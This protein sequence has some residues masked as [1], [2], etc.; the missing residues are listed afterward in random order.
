MEEMLY[1]FN[2]YTN[3]HIQRETVDEYVHA[4]IQTVANLQALWP[5][6]QILDLVCASSQKRLT[7]IFNENIIEDI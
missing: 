6:L 2:D 3:I 4:D 5:G 1:V 7:I